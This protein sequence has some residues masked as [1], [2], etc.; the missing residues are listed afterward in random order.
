MKLK[1]SGV[2]EPEFK[3]KEGKKKATS[4]S[5]GDHSQALSSQSAADSFLRKS[6]QQSLTRNDRAAYLNYRLRHE[7]SL[8]TQD[9]IRRKRQPS[10]D[11]EELNINDNIMLRVCDLSLPAR[12]KVEDAQRLE[13]EMK[14]KEARHPDERTKRLRLTHHKVSWTGIERHAG[15]KRR[16][17]MARGNLVGKMVQRME[18]VQEYKDEAK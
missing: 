17:Q 18:S 11:S 2:I 15:H 5:L 3:F 1:A 10:L 4:M 14:D 16:K 13:K 7:P 6:V 8:D 12:S 9:C